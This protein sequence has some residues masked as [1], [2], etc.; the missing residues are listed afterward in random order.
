MPRKR[1]SA[2]NTG[3][4]IVED[5]TAAYERIKGHAHRTPV[6]RSRTLD[7]E[8]GAEVLFKC[9]NLQRTGSYKIRGAYYKLHQLKRSGGRHRVIAASAGN[10]A[11]GVAYAARERAWSASSS[12]RQP[13]CPSA[14]PR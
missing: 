4:C 11:Q 14:A 3:I 6:M 2:S 8:L 12:C 9:E 7:K 5:V 1:P 10:H 13:R